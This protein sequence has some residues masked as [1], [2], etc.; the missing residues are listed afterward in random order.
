MSYRIYRVAHYFIIVRVSTGKLY[1]FTTLVTVIK[2]E[3]YD[4]TTGDQLVDRT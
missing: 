3:S 2:H 4:Q 1:L